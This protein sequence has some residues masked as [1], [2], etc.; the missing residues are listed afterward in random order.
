MKP[1]FLATLL[2]LEKVHALSV[3]LLRQRE[4]RYLAIQG[5]LLFCASQQIRACT[6]AN[7]HFKRAPL[8]KR[9]ENQDRVGE[10]VDRA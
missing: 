4:L 10:W 7:R 8:Q 9:R 1:S 6:S 3:S 5:T 2:L